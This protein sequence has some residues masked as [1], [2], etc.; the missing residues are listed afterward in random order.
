MTT[1]EARNVTEAEYQKLLAA[2]PEELRRTWLLGD[3]LLP[4]RKELD[5][6]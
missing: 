1:E 5:R 3:W 6:L 4:S 2:L